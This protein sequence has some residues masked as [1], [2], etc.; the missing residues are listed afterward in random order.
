MYLDL[1]VHASAAVHKRM[2]SLILTSG[3][4]LETNRRPRLGIAYAG[5]QNLQGP[6]DH[7]ESN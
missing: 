3:N 2:G 4:G 7:S 5:S 1:G 6:R